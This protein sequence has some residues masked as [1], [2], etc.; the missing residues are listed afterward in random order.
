[1]EQVATDQEVKWEAPELH[2][3][4]GDQSYINC[5]TLIS[6]VIDVTIKL[7]TIIVAN[8]HAHVT[9]QSNSQL[10]AQLSH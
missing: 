6:N 9:T 5:L 7:H 3:A 1:M 8:K 2:S 4:A 10:R